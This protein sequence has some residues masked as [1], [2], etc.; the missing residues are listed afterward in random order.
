MM[1]KL[2][3]KQE[4]FA[5]E[6]LC[7]LNATQA[8]IRAGYSKKSAAIIGHENLRKPN[9]AAMIQQG[10]ERRE[11]ELDF[12]AVDVLRELAKLG[13]ANMAD[14]MHKSA[15]GGLLFD[16]S[17]LTRDQSAALQEVTVEEFTTGRGGNA[18]EVRR[19]KVKLADKK[20]ALVDI[21]KHLGPGD[22]ESTKF[23]QSFST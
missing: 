8:A 1:S 7:D 4:L 17:K 16:L 6:Y 15:D 18:R 12:K 20:S 23:C 3:L 13:F 5:R 9:I 10:R 19:T 22:M 2:T 11:A 14:Y 21:G